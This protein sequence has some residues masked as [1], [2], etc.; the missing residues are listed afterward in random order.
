MPLH[1]NWS[2]KGYRCEFVDFFAAFVQNWDSFINKNLS[3]SSGS[4]DSLATFDC[5]GARA[6]DI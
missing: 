6:A 3:I 5:V 2:H 4:F 1:H